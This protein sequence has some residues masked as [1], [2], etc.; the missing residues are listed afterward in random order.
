MILIDDNTQVLDHFKNFLADDKA[1]DMFISGL[2]GTGK[3]W[4]LA[5]LMEH[6]RINEINGTATAYTNKAVEVLSMKLDVKATTMT[7]HA[8]LKKRPGI[9]EE[10]RK[11]SELN[12]S[13]VNKDLIEQA[14]VL[15]VD[16]F[17]MIGGKDH[18]SIKELQYK[19]DGSVDMK[20][21]YLGDPN[22]LPPIQDEQTVK[23]YGDYDLRLTKIHR[24]AGDNPLI[25]TLMKLNDC[26]NVGQYQELVMHET[27]VRTP[28]IS[29][30]FKELNSTKI[31]LGYTN[32]SVEQMNIAIQGR[33]DVRVEDDV[34]CPTHKE[35]YKI[36]NLVDPGN[37]MSILNNAKEE[38]ARDCK[39]RTIDR[40]QNL[41]IDFVEVREIDKPDRVIPVVF[42]HSSFN[43]KVKALAD[44][45]INSNL[46][47][48]RNYPN[49][50]LSGVTQWCRNN[51]A[52]NYLAQIRNK[53]W[54][55]Y[56][57][58]K[59]CVACIDFPHATT[60]HKSQGS[61]YEA[62]FIDYQDVLLARARG[63]R[64]FCRLLYVAVSRAAR[65]VYMN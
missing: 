55:D 24:Q 7:L 51:K 62:V 58:F 13:I 1:G 33:D 53:A 35:Y 17:S 20:V 54:S 59:T 37:V 21:V 19:T 16:E 63:D 65:I 30:K 41:N 29:K 57:L 26:I 28:V 6:C 42:G 45:A 22:Q 31:I 50:K 39:F 8:F 60:I 5:D 2:A 52:D 14:D 10:A 27:L 49:L 11:S 47:I 34:F 64:E 48:L 44:G 23:S 3:T 56:M 4:A 9:N 36:L 46:E 43:K 61:T 12:I 25:G 15:F 32:A 38:V 40:L 18:R